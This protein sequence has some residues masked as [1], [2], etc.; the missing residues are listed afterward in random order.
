MFGKHVTSPVFSLAGAYM[1]VGGFGLFLFLNGFYS[2]S[3]LFAWGT[4]VTFMGQTITE[5]RTYYLTLLALFVHQNVNN[6]VNSVV[7]PWLLNCVQDP[8][9][10]TSGYSDFSTLVLVCLFDLYSEIDMILV[11]SGIA[12]QMG[13][14]A[15]IVAANVVSSS[16]INLQYLRQKRKDHAGDAGTDQDARGPDQ[17][18]I[19]P[20]DDLSTVWLPCDHASRLH[21]VEH[22]EGCDCGECIC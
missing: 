6:W 13:F 2:G 8:K 1:Y 12:S 5:L 15:A 21:D 16:A 19:P 9:S 7:Y 4:P 17:H 20:T 11:V 3:P 18:E 10:P 14:V 22:G